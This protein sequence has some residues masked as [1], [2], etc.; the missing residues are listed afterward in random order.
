VL[1]SALVRASAREF[2]LAELDATNA[3]RAITRAYDERMKSP[4]ARNR[5]REQ[6]SRSSPSPIRANLRWVRFVFAA[7]AAASTTARQ[8]TNKEWATFA[9]SIRG[10]LHAY[11]AADLVVMPSLFEGFGLVAAEAIATGCPVPRSRTRGTAQMIR[12]GI[13]GFECEIEAEKFVERLFQIIQEPEKLALDVG[14]P[15]TRQRFRRAQHR[16][17]R[18]RSRVRRPPVRGS[19]GN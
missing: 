17:A 19:A 5:R 3:T 16:I 12:E 4:R 18:V 14:G 1:D 10:W 15:R 2:A 8:L 7:R 11:F 9:S 6:A 13:S